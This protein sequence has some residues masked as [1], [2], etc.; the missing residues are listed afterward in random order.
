MAFHSFSSNILLLILSFSICNK[1]ISALSLPNLPAFNAAFNLTGPPSKD[2][3][4]K[5]CTGNLRWVS[6]G[7]D[8]SDCQS[9]LDYLFMEELSDGGKQTLEFYDEGALPV[10]TVPKVVT[11]RKYVFSKCIAF[12]I[13][14]SGAMTVFMTHSIWIETCTIAILMLESPLIKTQSLPGASTLKT[15]PVDIATWRQVWET[16]TRVCRQ[17][18]LIRNKLGWDSTGNCRNL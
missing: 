10:F 13:E 7:Y 16:A 6:P 5:Q 15:F 8:E 12:T 18:L 17:C 1:I 14:I 3:N 9:A 4:S 2:F 11:P